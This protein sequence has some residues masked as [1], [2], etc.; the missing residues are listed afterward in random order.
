MKKNR[1]L[2]LLLAAVLLTAL[3]LPALGIAEQPAGTAEA[4]PAAQ[5]EESGSAG[6][7]EEPDNRIL[8]AVLIVGGFGA[9][10]GVV[11][12]VVSK[13]FAV[14]SNPTRDAVREALPGANCGGCGY[15]GCDGCA[16]AIAAGKAAVS[17]CP[18]G[19]ADVAKKIGEI[20]GVAVD[21]TER[22]VARV[23]CQGG[24]DRCRVRFDYHGIMDCNAAVIVQDGY[25]ACRFAC[26][27]L[28]NC[29]RVCPFDAIHIDQ[30]KMIA[31]V[32]EN[33]C[34]SCGKCIAEC[35]RNVLELR[36]VSQ[37]VDM[38][39]RNAE[40]G[41]VVSQ[42]CSAGCIG[43][44]RCAK[45]CKFDAITIVNHLPVIDDSKCRHCMVC[46]EVCPTGAMS[47]EWEKRLEAVIDPNACIGCGMCKR[48]CQ[49][50]AI[51]GEMRQPHVV[52]DACTGCGVCAEKCP[53]KCITMRVREKARD[54]RVAL[55]VE[56]APAKPALTP[57]QQARVAAAKA[58]REAAAAGKQE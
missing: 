34:Q 28:G 51:A 25:K 37:P 48:S 3:L 1:I 13:V 54:P 30:A 57:E 18:V 33:K 26:L 49:F 31:V 29:E 6:T 45:A 11:L 32:D 38:L 44:E 2:G 10:F 58:A 39:C 36:P 20:M 12:T 19:G 24:T 5:N 27:G 53:K 17:A 23:I 56:A 35:P 41:K 47:T 21:A 55:H 40:M 46:A 8:W 9:L 42:K 16:D 15:P 43:C 14:P 7:K 50:G 52:N 22:K 4:L